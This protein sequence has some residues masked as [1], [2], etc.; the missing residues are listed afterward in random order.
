MPSA[1]DRFDVVVLGAGVIGLSV[2]LELQSAG[3][4]VAVVA[5]DLPGGTSTLWATPPLGP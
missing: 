1:P 2:A 5:K 3:F 4:K